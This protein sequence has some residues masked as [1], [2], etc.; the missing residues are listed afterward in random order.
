[1]AISSLQ[2]TAHSLVSIDY[3]RP[4]VVGPGT[5]FKIEVLRLLENAMLNKVFTN[6]RA[7]LLIFNAEFTDSVG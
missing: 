4:T 2:R 1:M 5:I 7:I 3:Y 6:N